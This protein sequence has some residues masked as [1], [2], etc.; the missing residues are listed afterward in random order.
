MLICSN[1]A[2]EKMYHIYCLDPPLTELPADDEDW[3][4]PICAKEMA[5]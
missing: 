3:F 5:V 1:E 2:C 4:C